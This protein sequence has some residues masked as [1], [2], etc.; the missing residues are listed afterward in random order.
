MACNVSPV[1]PQHWTG[2]IDGADGPLLV[3]GTLRTFGRP[4]PR[5][6]ANDD[7]DWQRLHRSWDQRFRSVR[8]SLSTLK[9]WRRR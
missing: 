1:P 4:H 7:A 6:V 9:W 2:A 8:C 3:L 5:L